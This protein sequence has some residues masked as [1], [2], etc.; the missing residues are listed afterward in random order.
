MSLRITASNSVLL[1]LLFASLGLSRLPS[2]HAQASDDDPLIPEG[3]RIDMCDGQP[4]EDPAPPAVPPSSAGSLVKNSFS[5]ASKDCVELGTCACPEPPQDK[6]CVPNKLYCEAV[7]T[8]GI[9]EAATCDFDKDGNCSIAP[10]PIPTPA[11]GS[12]N[13]TC[14]AEVR[15][16]TPTS[17]VLRRKDCYVWNK[18]GAL[19]RLILVTNGKKFCFGSGTGKPAI[20]SCQETGR[21]KG[22]DGIIIVPGPNTRCE[23]DATSGECKG[24]CN[25]FNATAESKCFLRSGDTKAGDV[26]C[27]KGKETSVSK[28]ALEAM[29][30]D[31]SSSL[32]NA[33]NVQAAAEILSLDPETR[34]GGCS[35][36]PSP[37]A[38]P[39]PTVTPNSV[40]SPLGAD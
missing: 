5:E 20:F 7:R 26:A 3:L 16:D 24:V 22:R 6:K 31:L 25:V 29:V 37:T 18:P 11:C 30:T 13:D 38:F 12:T 27:V 1:V 19:P 8:S 2:A 23:K 33:Q 17:C 28:S 15:I 4:L 36:T 40:V 39:T 21:E 10:R 9:T 14:N 34:D 35:P 32:P